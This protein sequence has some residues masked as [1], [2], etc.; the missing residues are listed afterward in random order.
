MCE[1]ACIKTYPKKSFFLKAG[2][3]QPAMGFVYE[4]LLRRYYINEKGNTITTGFIPENNY[5]ADYPAFIKQ[6][7]SKYFIEC[8]EASV[9]VELPYN[10]IQ[11]SYQKFQ[12]TERYGRLIAEYVLTL[13]TN[14]TESFLFENAEERYLNFIAEN[15]NLMHRISLTHLSSYLGI[16]RQSLSR[17]RKKLTRE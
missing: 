7:A 13:Q 3:V 6:K 12:N 16:E 14:R 2:E 4:G 5:A 10:K 11:E 17:I 1:G 8:L 15:Q 9:L